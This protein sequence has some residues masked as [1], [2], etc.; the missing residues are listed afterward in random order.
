MSLKNINNITYCEIDKTN[1]KSMMTL[2]HHL[3]K[4]N[5]DKKEYYDKFIRKESEGKCPV[6]KNECGFISIGMGYKKYCSD[7]C[8]LNDPVLNKQRRQNAIKTY[9]RK[10]G[11]DSFSKT[12]GFGDRVKQTKLIR[13]GAANYTNAEKRRKTCM[14]K[15][16]V[17]YSLQSEIVRAKGKQ[18]C[19]KKYGVNHQTQADVVKEK[20]RKTCMK[21][22]GVAYSLQSEK[23]KEKGKQTCLKKYGV[24]YSLQSEIVREKGKQTCLEKYGAKSPLQSELIKHK[25]QQTNIARYGGIVP[26]KCKAVIDK[27]KSTNLQRYGVSNTFNLIQTKNTFLER[28]GVINP[29]QIPEVKEKVISTCLKKYGNKTF[30]GSKYA[31]DKIKKTCLRK[32]GVENIMQNKEMYYKVLKATKRAFALKRYLT[33]FGNEI[34]YQSKPELEFIH[35]CEINNIFIQNGP[36]IGYMIDN[37]SRMYFVDFEI[38]D[39]SGRRLVEIKRKHQWWYQ[40]LKSGVI[41]EKA[42]AAIRFSKENKFLP[43]KILFENKV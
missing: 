3:K 16:G 35:L 26:T 34:F 17:A 29:S 38:V 2:L 8:K 32:Y 12:A 13:H 20:S 23:V 42:K 30:F 15:Y 39:D 31:T 27:I 9:L 11:V 14:E 19:L 5:V 22:Y 33:V 28:Y 41:R 6:C 24:A 10:Y 18:T 7:K 40:D 25:Q 36:A 43:Y 4:L 37:K 1:H 21:K